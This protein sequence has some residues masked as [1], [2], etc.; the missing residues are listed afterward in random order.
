ME[1]QMRKLTLLSSVT[2]V[3]LSVVGS[4]ANASNW[5]MNGSSCVPNDTSIN[6]YFVTGGSV[7]HKASSTN[8][9]I[10]Y[11]PVTATWGSNKPDNL[12]M[13][14]AN[15]RPGPGTGPPIGGIGTASITAQL[16]R[17]AR[18][19]GSLNFI[20]DPARGSIET[21][22]GKVTQSPL[23]SHSFDFK[24]SY[25]Y[26]RVDI[27]RNDPTAFAKLFGVSLDCETCPAD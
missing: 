1:G 15:N 2:M 16:I 17:L 10:L 5:S 14:Y 3:G 13:T 22:T 8:L 11:C 26:V 9:I 12:K 18:S 25:Y 24:F 19:D 23:F 21:Q 20:G 27:S 4:Q 6:D 7:T